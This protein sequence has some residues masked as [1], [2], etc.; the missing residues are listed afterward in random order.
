M[1]PFKKCLKKYQISKENINAYYLSKYG[2]MLPCGYNLKKK[3]LLR[4]SNTLKKI[5]DK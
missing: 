2:I 5:I 3:D 4:I 1:P